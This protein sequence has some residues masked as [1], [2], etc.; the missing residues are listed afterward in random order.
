MKFMIT[1]KLKVNADR[2]GIITSIACA[3]HCTVL[4]LF[5]SS[6]PFLNIDILENKTIEW[7]MI[8]LALIFGLLSLYHG[9]TLHHKKKLPLILFLAGFSFL[10]LNQVI[11]ERFVYIFIPASSI[12]IISAHITNTYFCRYSAKCKVHHKV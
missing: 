8:V 9:Y 1:K 2:W 5:I 6:I 7:S 4:P 3:I 10:V 11:A 12:S